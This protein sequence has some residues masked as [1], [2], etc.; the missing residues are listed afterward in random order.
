VKQNRISHLA[1]RASQTK[2]EKESKKKN[3]PIEAL[4]P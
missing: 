1:Y 4:G 3:G 2:K